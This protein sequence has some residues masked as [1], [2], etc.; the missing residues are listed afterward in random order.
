MGVNSIATKDINRSWK[1]SSGGLLL[2]KISNCGSSHPTMIEQ[3]NANKIKI[4]IHFLRY[5]TSA[6]NTSIR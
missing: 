3:A 1:P 5:S 6:F 2:I 4:L